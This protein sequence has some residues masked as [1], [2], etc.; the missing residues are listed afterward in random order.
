MTI[1]MD[2]KQIYF[3]PVISVLSFMEENALMAASPGVRPGKGG[4]GN[5]KVIELRQFGIKKC[6]KKLVISLLFCNFI[7]D[8]QLITNIYSDDYH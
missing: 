3:K 4:Q 8:N 5:I 1:V 2:R 7:V 6:P